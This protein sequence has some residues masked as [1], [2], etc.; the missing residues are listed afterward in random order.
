MKLPCDMIQ[1]L[2]PLYHDGV[3]SQVSRTLVEEHLKECPDCSGALQVIQTDLQM[4]KLEADEA[5]PLKSIRRRWTRKTWITGLMIGF[6][7]FFGW[8]Q[9]T[10]ASNVM[11]TPE[12]YE[13]TNVLELSNGMY[14]LE[15]RILYDYNGICANLRRTE[16]G[17]VYLHEARPILARRDEEKGMLRNEVIDPANHRTDMGTEIPM[18]AFYLGSPDSEDAVLLWSAEEDYP[19]ATPEEERE[20]LYQHIF[21]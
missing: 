16:D 3:C 10:Q 15:Y 19:L 17:C 4:P 13:I 20:H 2:L 18:T 9:L 14:Y 11:L 7:A 8:Y 5:K 12:D 1:D 6:A 21:R